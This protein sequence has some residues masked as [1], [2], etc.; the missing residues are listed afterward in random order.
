[1]LLRHLGGTDPTGRHQ[2]KGDRWCARKKATIQAVV[3]R[4][5]RHGRRT[6]IGSAPMKKKLPVIQFPK[7]KAVTEIADRS[8]HNGGRHRNR[9]LR[10]VTSESRQNTRQI[11]GSGAEP[12]DGVGCV[13]GHP[14]LQAS[15]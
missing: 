12:Q 1:M 3:H 15:P 9:P 8:W 11:P 4:G 6:R 2:Y 7:A 14:A 5:R 10:P 13:S